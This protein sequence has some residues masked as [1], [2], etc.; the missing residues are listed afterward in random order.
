M[1]LK[2]EKIYQKF[3]SR[4]K[5]LPNS[6]ATKLKLNKIMGKMRN[7]EVTNLIEDQDIKKIF[8][9]YLENHYQIFSGFIRWANYT[10]YST[11]NFVQRL[12]CA[13]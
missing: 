10:V 1:F 8:E 4:L 11:R 3:N 9:F 6:P 12:E 13:D 2:I 7:T 5:F